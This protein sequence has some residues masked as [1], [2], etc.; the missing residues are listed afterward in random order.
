[1]VIVGSA[2]ALTTRVQML[3]HFRVYRVHF[4]AWHV[5]RSKEPVWVAI[6][7]DVD[8]SNDDAMFGVR[9]RPADNLSVLTLARDGLQG[10][11][12]GVPSLEDWSS[13]EDDKDDA[14]R[15]EIK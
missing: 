4:D 10:F 11:R 13:R 3:R 1:M 14:F 9:T 2:R 6:R 7:I 5:T 8:F 15:S 12:P